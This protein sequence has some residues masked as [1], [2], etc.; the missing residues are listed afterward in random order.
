MLV[1][2]LDAQISDK[3]CAEMQKHN[4]DVKPLLLKST[5]YLQ[6]VDRHYGVRVKKL[7]KIDFRGLLDRQCKRLEENGRGSKITVSQLRI[8]VSKWV[9]QAWQKVSADREFMINT[10]RKTGLSLPIDGSKDHEMSFL[11]VEDLEIPK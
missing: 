7:V 9:G 1:D 4:T 5:K 6:P 10:F 3:F 8:L 2:N 11:D